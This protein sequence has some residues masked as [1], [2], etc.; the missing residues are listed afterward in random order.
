MVLIHDSIAGALVEASQHAQLVVVG[1]RGHGVV[2]GALLGS[3]GLQ[4]L[5]HADCPV[6]IARPRARERN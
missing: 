3:A 2:A 6:Y 1:S 4:L 5:Q